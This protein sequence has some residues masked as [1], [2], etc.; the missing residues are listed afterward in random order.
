MLVAE[1]SPTLRDFLVNILSAEADIQVVATAVDG[2]QAVE[3]VGR[4][5]PD[6]VTMDI[7]M[8]RLNGFEATRRIMETH[9]V[10]IVI[11]SSTM[12]DQVAATFR[13]IEAG[14]LAFVSRPHGIGHP[15]RA[16]SAAE[17]VQTVRLMA[18]VK[19]VRRWPK[20]EAIKPRT[21]PLAAPNISHR[22]GAKIVAIGA[23]TGGPI[24]F[25]TILAGL[26][27]DFS[28]PL[29]VVQHIS[30][31]FVHGFVEWLGASSP[32]PVH[33]AQPGDRPLAG[34]VY[35]APDGAHMGIGADRIQLT[36]G[37]PEN[38]I[39]PAISYLFRSVARAFGANTAGVLLSGMGADGAVELKQLKD[40]GAV[41]IAQSK[42]SSVVHGM[43]GVAIGLGGATHVLGPEEIAA[44]LTQW[45]R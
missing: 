29:L 27:P 25:Q 28:A 39:R 33:L 37:A 17:L 34:H 45:V 4:L 11:V 3:A 41:T 43:P 5:K 16:S 24:A 38:G 14:A 32:L 44:L 6:V 9:P 1:D 18:E 15:D 12:S 13:A 22:P 42:E 2:V 35:L 26:P 23:S 20:P 19:V 10:P 8:P 21:G 36:A 7:H 40:I 30:P 31:G